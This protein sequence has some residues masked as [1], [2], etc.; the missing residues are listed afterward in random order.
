MKLTERKVLDVLASEFVGRGHTLAVNN[1]YM[2]SWRNES[3]LVSITG[4]GYIWEYEVKLSKSDFHADFKKLR[5]QRYELQ[6]NIMQG[7]RLR[8]PNRFWYVTP[9][10]LVSADDLPWYA[11]LITVRQDDERWFLREVRHAPQLHKIKPGTADLL[12]LGRS[13]CERYWKMRRR[14][15]I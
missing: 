15:Q 2:F 4:T 12:R 14:G 5:H 10:G 3:D 1:I 13:V 8:K 11:G 7:N 6:S 9:V